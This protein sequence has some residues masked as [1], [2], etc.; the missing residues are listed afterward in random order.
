MASYIVQDASLA[1]VADAIRAKAGGTE[2][3]VFPAGFVEAVDGIEGGGLAPN[4]RIYQ[5]GHVTE[6]ISIAGCITSN[7]SCALQEG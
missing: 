1:A 2:K 4:E 6:S 5:V 3:L 7:A